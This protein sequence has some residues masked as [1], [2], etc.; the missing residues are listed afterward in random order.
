[1]SFETMKHK[2]LEVRKLYADFEKKKYG[3]NWNNEEL[4]LGLM[5]D[6]GDLAKLVQ[7]QNNIRDIP[8]AD[9]K[10]K[11]EISDCIW[12]LIVLA[13]EYDIDIA[14]EFNITM[15]ELKDDLWAKLN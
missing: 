7:A 1:M 11:H 9:K 15:D 12:S 5:G 14:K 3:R 6:I 2:A 10:I 4:M 13:D 8:E